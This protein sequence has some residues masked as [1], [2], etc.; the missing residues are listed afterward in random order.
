MHFLQMLIIHMR[1]YLCSCDR[2]VAEQG[3]YSSDVSPFFDESGSE[4]MSER[5]RRHFF[6]DASEC[7][8]F[9]YYIFNAVSAEMFSN[10]VFGESHEK[11]GT[12]ICPEFGICF[13]CVDSV[14]CGEY[15]SEL[16]SF[17]YDRK[18]I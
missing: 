2:S 18:L 4:T 7:S 14:F 13:Q 11:V 8:V 5:M 1:I 6:A 12:C 16:R 17:S 10:L 3:L 15:R 9:L